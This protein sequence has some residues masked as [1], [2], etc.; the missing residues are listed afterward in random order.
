M[1]CKICLRDIDE[2]GLDN[3]SPFSGYPVC[4]DCKDEIECDSCNDTG[5]L[6]YDAESDRVLCRQC[7]VR[8]AEKKGVI[9]SGK[10]FFDEDWNRIGD[11]TDLGPIAE[12]LEDVMEL[13][14]AEV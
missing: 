1:I 7:L 6:Y 9:N 2:M 3:V 4:E 8:E 5:T 13:Q 10:V 14:R 12:H 11:D